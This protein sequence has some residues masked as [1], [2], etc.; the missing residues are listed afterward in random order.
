[1]EAHQVV[2]QVATREELETFNG[3]EPTELMFLSGRLEKDIGEDS[4]VAL[5][6]PWTT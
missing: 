1:M 2:S 3:K 4:V 6:F 5:N